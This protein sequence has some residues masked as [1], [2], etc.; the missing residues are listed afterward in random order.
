MC[1]VG[2]WCGAEPPNGP[3]GSDPGFGNRKTRHGNGLPDGLQGLF[4]QKTN[5]SQVPI[6]RNVQPNCTG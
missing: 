2:V 6:P 3:E 5:L 1:R 4:H